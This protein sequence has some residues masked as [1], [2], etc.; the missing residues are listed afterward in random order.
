MLA[1][2]SLGSL[3]LMAVAMMAAGS[4]SGVLAGLFGIG[5][6]AVLVPILA[7]FL[8]LM[9]VD[10]S[11]RMHMAVGTSLAIIVPTAIRSYTAHKQRGAPDQALLRGWALWVP[12]GV[13]LASFFVASIPGDVLRAIFAC[14]ALLIALK[15]LLN[16]DSWTLGSDLPRE[17]FRAAAGFGIGVISTFMGIGGG[18]LN[19]VFMTSFG[20]PIHQAVATSAGLGVLIAVPGALGYAIAGWGHADLPP[21]SLGYINGLALITIMPVALLA[22]P[23]GVRL[24]HGLSKR[25]MER[26]FGVFLLIVA[27]RFLLT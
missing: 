17:P 7:E 15:M 13:V 22:A 5:G 20:R 23:F 8:G 14:V 19:N 3:G 2:T 26:L 25:S 24:A 18:N 9:G 27:A 12:A 11:V 21:L 4:L 10:D 16:R 1:A 6:G